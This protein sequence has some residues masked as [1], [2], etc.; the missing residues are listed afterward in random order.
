MAIKEYIN[1][2]KKVNRTI[3]LDEKGKNKLIEMYPQSVN[4]DENLVFLRKNNF[5]IAMQLSDD[6]NFEKIFEIFGEKDDE[7]KEDIITFDSIKYLY[8]AFTDDSPKIKLILITFLLFGK[9]EFMGKI[10][11]TNAILYLFLKPTPFINHLE[12]IE[13]IYQKE[14]KNNKKDNNKKPHKQLKTEGN[15]DENPLEISIKRSDFIKYFD[16]SE[17]KNSKFM[18]DFHFLK[19]IEGI[20]EFKFDSNNKNKNNLDFYCDCAK[21]IDLYKPVAY[22]DN[23]DSMKKAFD[24]LT[25]STNKALKFEDL[26]KILERNKIEPNLIYLTIDYLKKITLKEFC[27]FQDIKDLFTNLQY[28]NP[29]E[30]KKRFLFKMISTI[31]KNQTKLTYKQI[32]EYLDITGEKKEDKGDTPDSNKNNTDSDDTINK[33]GSYDEED[34][35]KNEIFDKMFNKLKE[36]LENFGLL[37]YTEFKVKTSDKQIRKKLIN[38]LFKRDN[39]D[40][41]EKYLEKHFET[42]DFFYAID[43]KFW[44]VLM[45]P[46]QEA[47]DF[48]DNSKIAEE[49][50]IITEEQ[51]YRNIENERIKKLM[52]EERKKREAKERKKLSKFLG[53]KD[54]K[55]NQTTIENDDKKKEAEQKKEEIVTKSAKLKP[56]LKYKTDFIVLCGKLF[57]IVRTNYKMNYIIRIRKI[58]ELISLNPKQQINENQIDKEKDKSQETKDKENK[59]TNE[60]SKKD[61]KIESELLYDK[62]ELEEKEKLINEKLDKFVVDPDKNLI[63]KIVRYDQN[64]KSKDYSTKY[65]LYE[66]DFYPIQIYTKTF[67]IFVREV[68]KAK[69]KFEQLE[70]TKLFNEASEKEKRKMIDKQNKENQKIVNKSQEYYDRKEKI[71]ERRLKDIITNEEFNQ[72]LKE[73]KEE[74]SDIFNKKDKTKDD[75]EVDITMSEFIDTLARYKNDILYNENGK[76]I[77]LRQRYKKFKDIKRRIINDNYKTLYGKEFKIY[78]FLFNDKSLFE[79]ADDFCF[80]NND[81][82]TY[83]PF[84]CI[85]VDIYN[86]KGECFYDLLEKK[87]LE[88]ENIAKKKEKEKEKEK[89]K[90]KET[91]KA[92]VKKTKMTEEE[93]K[94][95]KEKE[96]KKN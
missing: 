8:C 44:K 76:N 90:I 26:K 4:N 40:D 2:A 46:E 71:R 54:E 64:T 48:L 51:K 42:S 18:N 49:V 20:S 55:Q 52:E 70:K 6:K 47:P 27:F 14:G 77:F 88:P 22:E 28:K 69:E 17:E 74:Y 13:N 50:D 9:N 80:E 11:L 29:F 30:D 32:S 15:K 37:P 56:G 85:I 16:L 67:G 41:H 73:L 5:R 82:K 1:K 62:E 84:V 7:K 89:N 83:E 91:V 87:E 3:T 81:Y 10:D 58:Q 59:E 43:I 34:F 96:N 38:D 35:M 45:D 23:L 39:I 65:L 75:Y 66:I 33:N 95:L 68:E 92:E 25:Y 53:K 57:D 21:K 94:A 24:D 12:H 31:N 78:F 60:E 79:P 19:Q 61:D 36:P 63:S 93:K 86:E 72:Q